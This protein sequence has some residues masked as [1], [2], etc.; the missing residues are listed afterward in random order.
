MVYWTGHSCLWSISSILSPNHNVIAK[1]L[2]SIDWYRFIVTSFQRG[3]KNPN[4]LDNISLI[5][6]WHNSWSWKKMWLMWN[7]SY[8]LSQGH[9][10]IYAQTNMSSNCTLRKRLHFHRLSIWFWWASLSLLK[11][12][13]FITFPERV[14]WEPCLLTLLLKNKC[15]LVKF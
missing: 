4:K 11:Y 13:N 5:N 3:K 8:V 1:S 6:L 12:D 9:C 15:W 2:Q 14:G 10:Q 7:R